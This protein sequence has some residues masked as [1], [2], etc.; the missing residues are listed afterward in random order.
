[1]RAHVAAKVGM[2]PLFAML[3][4]GVPALCVYV[5]TRRR[6]RVVY[7]SYEKEFLTRSCLRAQAY[8]QMLRTLAELVQADRLN[9]FTKTLPVAELT[10]ATLSQAC[11]VIL[12]GGV[13]WFE[14]S[15]VLW[16]QKVN[17]VKLH[18]RLIASPQSTV[19]SPFCESSAWLAEKQRVCGHAVSRVSSLA[20]FPHPFRRHTSPPFRHPPHPFAI[21][22]HPFAT[23]HTFSPPVPQP[24]SPP[25]TSFPHLVSTFRGPQA[26][27]SHR[28]KQDS[29]NFR[30]RT[31]LT[32]GDE[33]G[34]TEMYFNIA[35]QIRKLE[36]G[37]EFD[38]DFEASG[39]ASVA[40][41]APSDGGSQASKRWA[42][43]PELLKFLSLEQYTEAFVEVV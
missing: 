42:D 23:H 43:A 28:V 38:D 15:D 11:A 9:V 22:F 37:E 35:A 33:K 26:L 16:S 34:A 27:K 21:C 40:A 4:A 29:K 24:F 12:C 7:H 31:V 41:S 1:M 32:F 6:R 2:H 20:N 10:A 39:G 30:E 25:T 18:S 8:L 13:L 3:R 19:P 17:L 14:V 36:N 5:R